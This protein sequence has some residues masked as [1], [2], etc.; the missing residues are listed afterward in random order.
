MQDSAP[1]GSLGISVVPV[2]DD[3]NGASTVGAV[4]GVFG[5]AGAVTAAH[6]AS[7]RVSPR[8]QRRH[9]RCSYLMET[10]CHGP[11][12]WGRRRQISDGPNVTVRT[13][14]VTMRVRARLATVALPFHEGAAFVQVPIRVSQCRHMNV[15]TCYFPL[16]SAVDAHHQHVFPTRVLVVGSS[17]QHHS[18]P[19][20]VFPGQESRSSTGRNA[21]DGHGAFV[22]SGVSSLN[23]IRATCRY[24]CQSGYASQYVQVPGEC[25]TDGSQCGA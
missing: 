23:A 16:Q 1:F 3:T 8:R 2:R 4:G 22:S 17:H 20:G 13:K 19:P 6:H 5:F 7:F 21:V 11:H 24:S 15:S 25:S 10:S 18:H 9:V 12:L 14:P